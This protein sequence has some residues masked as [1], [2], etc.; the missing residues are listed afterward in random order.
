MTSCPGHIRKWWDVAND[1]R[2]RLIVKKYQ[3]GGLS[4]AQAVELGMLQTIAELMISTYSPPPR[5]HETQWACVKCL[6]KHTGHAM[7]G[8][9]ICWFC[10]FGVDI[11]HLE[12]KSLTR[13]E[14]R[15][16]A[17]LK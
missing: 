3:G 9:G 17:E 10:T 13:A 11:L 14:D 15:R 1:R 2:Q 8:T 6:E 12:T 4:E 7:L 5:V 16:K